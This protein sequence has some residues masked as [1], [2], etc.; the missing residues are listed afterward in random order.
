VVLVGSR[1]V[2]LNRLEQRGDGATSWAAGRLECCLD[3][4][5]QF[6]PTEQVQTDTLTV[7]EVAGV[8]IKRLGLGK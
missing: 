2:I 3:G 4:L 6:D 8:V 7:S 5:N 1:E